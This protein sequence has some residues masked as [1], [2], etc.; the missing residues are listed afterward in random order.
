MKTDTKTYINRFADRKSAAAFAK[1][2]NASVERCPAV[3]A[4]R[5]GYFKYQ[6]ITVGRGVRR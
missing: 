1:A 5:D 3:G 4:N 6:V 2:N